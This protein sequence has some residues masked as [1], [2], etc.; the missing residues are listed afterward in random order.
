MA[1]A[2]GLIAK[3]ERPAIIAGTDVYWDGAWDDLRAAVE[4]LRVPTFVNGLGRGCLPADHELAFSR[5]RGLLKTRGRSGGRHRH[6]AR[7]PPVLRPLRRRQGRPRRRLVAATGRPRPGRAVPG[8]P[9]RQGPGRLGR[10]HG[11]PGGPRAVDRPP[12][13]P[14]GLR[15]RATKR[16]PWRP[17]ARPSSRPA[18]TARSASASTGTPWSST[19]AATSCRTRAS[20]S[21]RTS[22]VAGWIPGPTAASAPA[23]ATPSPPAS[24]APTSRSWS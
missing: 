20:T 5:T 17:T 14:R 24:P 23:S 11:R 16:P 1:Q 3:A 19:T 6:P 7:L 12:A 13:G 10:P 8:R 21:T 2:A 4:H 22:P 9:H 15:R 18:S